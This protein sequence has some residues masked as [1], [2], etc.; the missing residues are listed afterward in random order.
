MKKKLLN[1]MKLRTATMLAAV[2]VTFLGLP[3]K[4]WAD[5]WLRTGDTWDAYSHKLTVNSDPPAGAYIHQDIVY[6]IIGN[7][8]KNIGDGAF[9]GCNYL[10]FLSIEGDLKSIGDDAFAGTSLENV[11]IP[12][13]VN[14]IG[15]GAFSS[16][17]SIRSFSVASENTTYKSDNDVLMSKDGKTLIA[18]PLIKMLRVIPSLPMWKLFV[19]VPL[20]LVVG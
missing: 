2:V 16:C 6:L 17:N 15:N 1:L 5:E 3:T 14:H 10:G 11:I 18:I 7:N 8:V 20:N 12:A 9:N 13:S 19:M 4:A